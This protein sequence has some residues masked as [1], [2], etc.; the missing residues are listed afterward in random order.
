MNVRS[1]PKVPYHFGT[2]NLPYVPDAIIA[3]VFLLGPQCDRQ[4]GVDVDES[5][6]HHVEQVLVALVVSAEQ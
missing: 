1:A 4:V 3:D 6:L 5:P 2:F